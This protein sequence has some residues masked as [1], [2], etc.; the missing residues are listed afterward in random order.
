MQ[1]APIQSR[2]NPLSNLMRQPKI[3]VKLPSRGKYWPPDS[4]NI[5]PNGEYPVYS[6]T[7]KD[8]LALKTPDALL[9]GQ[10]VVDIIQSCV[11]NITNAWN[12]PSIDIDALLIAI[13]LATYG[14]TMETTVTVA[15]VDGTYGIDLRTLL[16]Q[17]YESIIWDERIEI[18]EK[19]VIYVKPLTYKNISKS[20]AETFE[21]QKIMQLVNN[22]SIS[23][24]EKIKLFKQSFNKLTLVTLGVVTDSIYKIDTVD[25][26][27]TDPEFISEFIENCDREIFNKIKDHLDELV[28]K[29]TI[30]PMRVKATEEMVAAGAAEEV[31]VPL[32]FDASAFFG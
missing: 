28:K 13:R 19:M 24:E 21:T 15:G 31:E 1:K 22:D 23:E 8:E 32:V 29:N 26:S 2:V 12:V 10:A 14:E 11:P 18:N 4:I 5:S 17:L 20:S 25:G 16:D 7:A 30:K 9:N 3:Y 6:M 27:V